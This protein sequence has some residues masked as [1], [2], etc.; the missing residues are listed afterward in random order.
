MIWSEN[1]RFYALGALCFAAAGYVMLR[2]DYFG[3]AI[4][5]WSSS[6]CCAIVAAP[7]SS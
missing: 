2:K 1:A 6:A 3:P 4:L 5:L 7:R